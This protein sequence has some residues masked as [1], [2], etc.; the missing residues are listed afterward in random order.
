MAFYS[1]FRKIT[2]EPVLFSYMMCLFMSYPLIQQLAFKKI[3]HEKYNGEI[4]KNLTKS[5]EIYVQQKTSKWIL[6]QSVALTLPSIFASLLLG[7]WS[8][9]VGRKVILI[10]PSVG[11]VLLYINYIM[12]AAFFSLNVNY[13]IIGVSISALFGGFATTLLG[14]FSYISDITDKS[15]RT[16]RVA[17]LESM[18]FLGGT[19][20][21]LVGGVLVEHHGFMPAFGLCLALNVLIILYVSLVL[22][23]SYYP[24]QDQEGNW[25]LLAVHNHLKASIAVLTK[26]RPK[27]QRLNLLVIL[28]GI[29]SFTLI[30][31]LIA[32]GSSIL[33]PCMRSKLSKQVE[34]SELGTMFALTASLEVLETL[35]ASVIFNNIY[36]ATVDW[37]PG[38]CYLLMSA[39]ILI[40]IFLMIWLYILQRRD[41]AYSAMDAVG[42]LSSSEHSVNYGSPSEDPQ[43]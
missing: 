35:L 6:Y 26:T 25:A 4:C 32:V 38:F 21:N 42:I 39:I 14:V 36:S 29:L 16:T 23:E 24:Q 1:H 5:Q 11:S 37:M 27:H 10:L 40:P 7:S 33:P 13:I 34:P 17:V 22:P 3:C 2:V 18:I 9:K 30:S 15:Q 28:F 31:G 43:A 20:G 12:N 41:D 19:A 8:D